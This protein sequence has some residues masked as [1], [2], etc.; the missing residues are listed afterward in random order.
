MAN[1]REEEAIDFLVRFHGNRDR[2]SKLVQ[3]EIEEM[4][5][6]IKLDGIDK[7]WWDC[8]LTVIDP[9]LRLTLQTALCSSPRTDDGGWPRS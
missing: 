3:L 9:Q 8:T 6:N 2:S 7:R 1:G 4:R 5:E